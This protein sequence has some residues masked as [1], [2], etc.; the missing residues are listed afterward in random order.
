MRYDQSTLDSYRE[1]RQWL[2]E[3][4]KVVEIWVKERQP[5]AFNI[6]W[7][8]EKLIGELAI[9][10]EELEAKHASNQAGEAVV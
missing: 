9:G 6:Q 4:L 2:Q 5:N 7:H 1:E 3:R 8:M 10:I